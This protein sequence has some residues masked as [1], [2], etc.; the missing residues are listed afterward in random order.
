MVAWFD[1]WLRA[2]TT[3]HGLTCAY[4]LAISSEATDLTLEQ[5]RVRPDQH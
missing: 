4:W 5:T 2:A 1:F 3:A